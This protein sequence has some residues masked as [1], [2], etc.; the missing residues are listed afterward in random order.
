MKNN[1]NVLYA[2]DENYAPFLGVS[3]TSLFE[4]NKDIDSITV[5]A[6]L[7]SVSE[8]NKVKF[9]KTADKYKRTFVSIN[10]DSFNKEL[11]K[12][13]V[14]KYRGN[15]TTNY[16]LFFDQIISSDAENMLYIDCDTLI[17]S[18]LKFLLNL[19]WNG[20]VAAVVRDSLATRYKKLIGFNDNDNYFNAGVLFVNVYEWKAQDISQILLNHIKNNRSRYC[21]PDQDLLN[22]VLKGKTLELSPEYNFQPFH[23]VYKDSLYYKVYGNIGYYSVEQIEHARKNPVILHTYRFLGEFPWHKD[24]LHPDTPLFDD[25]LSKSLWK[26]YI[27]EKKKLSLIFKIEK[28]LYIAL[29][30]FLFLIL[31]NIAQFRSFYKQEIALKKFYR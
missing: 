23:R 30:K 29:P 13:N 26:D 1:L 20:N 22:I 12:L 9:R 28:I 27:K 31:F 17:C 5:Y 10:A 4:N 14:P 21:N 6:V 19:A 7:D 11:E 3:M 25:Y 8:E 2:A 24:N 16:R 18:S 15:Y